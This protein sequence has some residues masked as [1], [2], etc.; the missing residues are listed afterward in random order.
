MWGPM[1][2]ISTIL[3]P[4]LLPNPKMFLACAFGINPDGTPITNP[5]LLMEKLKTYKSVKS[6]EQY[7]YIIEVLTN[8]GNNNVLKA[9]SPEDPDANACR[10]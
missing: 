4:L 9:A 7:N 3:M 1:L 8:W 2:W 10:S 6:V 5:S